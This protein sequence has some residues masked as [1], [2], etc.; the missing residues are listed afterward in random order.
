M[1]DKGDPNLESNAQKQ[2]EK[3][4][5]KKETNEHI[6]PIFRPLISVD[7][8]EKYASLHLKEYHRTRRAQECDKSLC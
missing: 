7:G 3:N 2:K 4:V 6:Y 8:Q 1:W 5:E